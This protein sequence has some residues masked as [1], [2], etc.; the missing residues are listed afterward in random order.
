MR[1]TSVAPEFAAELNTAL[2]AEGRNSLC[3]Q[4]DRIEI[5]HFTYEGRDKLGYVYFVR[6]PPSAHFAA[7]AAQ[8]AET[9]V[10][11]FESGINV[12]V[13]HDGNL[14]GVELVGRDDV[15][16]KFRAKNA[17]A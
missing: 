16:V 14:F 10:F 8:V 6:P 17:A 2:K 11:Y 4:I 13:D 15:M 7:L 5:D 3:D 12:D 1:L 9:V